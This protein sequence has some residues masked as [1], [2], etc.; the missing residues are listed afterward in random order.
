MVL[1]ELHKGLVMARLHHPSNPTH[2]FKLERWIESVRISFATR[3]LGITLEIAREWGRMNAVGEHMGHR[4][5]KIDSLL[6]A[7]ARV[8]GMT[9][10]TRN[11]KHVKRFD[12]ELL[13]PFQ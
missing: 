2:A 9:L 5:D 8:Y 1:G 3:V 11:I 6:A 10:V 7:T 12:V 13:N 4:P